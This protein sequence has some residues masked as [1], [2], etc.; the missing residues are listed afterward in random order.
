LPSKLEDYRWSSKD[1]WEHANQCLGAL[2]TASDEER[3]N[4]INFFAGAILDLYNKDRAERACTLL[5]RRSGRKLTPTREIP[6]EITKTFPSS[7]K[8][9]ISPTT[10][11][12]YYI[13]CPSTTQTYHLSLTQ[14][15]CWSHEIPYRVLPDVTHLVQKATPDDLYLATY[16]RADPL[17]YAKYGAWYVE[18]ARW[19]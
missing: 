14:I 9:A 2:V 19:E 4:L 12:T 11:K 8:P 1:N 10:G 5:N 16:S 7:R 17:I 6:K 3:S 15:T 13:D 18:L